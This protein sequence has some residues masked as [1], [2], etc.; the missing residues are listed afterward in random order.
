MVGI[1]CED[2]ARYLENSGERGWKR[3][4]GTAGGAIAAIAGVWIAVAKER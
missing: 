3:V 2:E 1:R 4:A